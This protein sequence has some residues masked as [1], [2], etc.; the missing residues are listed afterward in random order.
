MEE[1]FI[2]LDSIRKQYQSA[3]S[4]LKKH[5]NVEL[6]TQLQKVVDNYY[7][8]LFFKNV[9]I[10]EKYSNFDMRILGPIL[11]SIASIFEG[12]EF[13][14]QDNIMTGE[15]DVNG[16]YNNINYLMLVD[17]FKWQDNF[18]I[19]KSSFSSRTNNPS[20][21][22]FEYEEK[23]YNAINYYVTGEGDVKPVLEGTKFPYLKE[24]VD[25]VITYRMKNNLENIKEDVLLSLRKEFIVS[26]M[27]KITKKVAEYDKAKEAD[28]QKQ[29][30]DLTEK[31][32]S[33]YTE[34]KENRKLLLKKVLG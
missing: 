17:S 33:Q 1:Y 11:A 20:K 26:H 27:E 19:K 30:R 25:F 23:F 34:E 5:F 16:Y 10:L 3:S 28:I 18:I 13:V 29:I 22:T 32:N 9:K 21:N 2:M 15:K 31:L 24:F 6:L 12:H 7:N 8:E 4:H 14:Y